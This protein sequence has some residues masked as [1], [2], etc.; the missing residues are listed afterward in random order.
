MILYRL[1]VYILP[2][3][4]R[5]VSQWWRV[6]HRWQARAKLTLSVALHSVCQSLVSLLECWSSS[7]RLPS[8]SA[9]PAQVPPAAHTTTTA[10]RATATDTAPTRPSA[11]AVTTTEATATIKLRY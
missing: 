2:C 10:V 4:V 1:V 5:G 11:A 6:A 7:S 8:F 9:V 3:R